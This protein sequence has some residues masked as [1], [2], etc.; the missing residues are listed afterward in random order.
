MS[1]WGLKSLGKY[2]RGGHVSRSKGEIQQL[3][4]TCVL[5]VSWELQ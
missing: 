5:L 4:T 3:K 1:P 2:E